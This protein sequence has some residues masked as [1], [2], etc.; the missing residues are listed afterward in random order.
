MCS[1]Y[2][3]R[4][5][6]HCLVGD[7]V[8]LSTWILG[9]YHQPV[10]LRMLILRVT[11]MSLMLILIVMEVDIIPEEQVWPIPY[12]KKTWP[13][14]SYGRSVAIH[15]QAWMLYLYFFRKKDIKIDWKYDHN[16][17][18]SQSAYFRKK[19]FVWT[20]LTSTNTAELL[21]IEPEFFNKG[22]EWE[23]GSWLSTESLQTLQ[24]ILVDKNK[25]TEGTPIVSGVI[26]LFLLRKDQ[27]ERRGVEIT[28]I[29]E[30]KVKSRRCA[31]TV[32]MF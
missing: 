20:V 5:N 27:V 21:E 24:D 31:H 18:E 23:L 26:V 19:V 13:R 14:A 8:L 16:I 9:W 7:L 12:T 1:K 17:L 4:C 2:I 28:W 30:G 3:T 29:C 15:W 22:K 32:C 25:A 6:R 11:M 10:V